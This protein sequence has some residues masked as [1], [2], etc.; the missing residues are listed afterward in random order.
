MYKQA[1]AQA[2]KP[3]ICPGRWQSQQQP[4]S[5]ASM[6]QVCWL[7]DMLLSSQHF[8]QSDTVLFMILLQHRTRS[9]SRAHLWKC[10]QRPSPAT[11]HADAPSRLDR[12]TSEKTGQSM[13][14]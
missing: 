2:L 3:V 8:W 1:S 14:W 11:S 13:S 6:H 9:K 4:S 7:D 5:V 10:G 12:K